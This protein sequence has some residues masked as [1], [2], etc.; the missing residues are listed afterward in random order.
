MSDMTGEFATILG[1]DAKFK[2]EIM[3][4]KGL[5]ILGQFEGQIRAKGTLHIA[6]GAKVAAQIEAANVKVDGEVKGNVLCT[7]KLHLTSSAKI[8]GDLR[9]TRL[10]MSDGAQFIGHVAV[11]A[12]AVEAASRREPPAT[13]PGGV[14]PVD[15]GPGGPPRP[16][17]IPVPEP[18][19]V[20]GMPGR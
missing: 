7:E 19:Q 3:F 4:E 8:D 20:A 10:E 2:G 9:A 14:R 16:R 5:R 17:P 18:A 1:Q 6:E 13:L 15:G 11:G 12:A